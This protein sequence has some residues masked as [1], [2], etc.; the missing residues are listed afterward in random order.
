M[1][2]AKVAISL[3]EHVLREI[4]RWVAAGEYPSRSQAMQAAIT[5]LQEQRVRRGALIEQLA[6]LDP[7][8]EQALADELLAAETTWPEF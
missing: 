3:D 7:A 6:K 5:V 1:P 2:A 4:D 8:Q